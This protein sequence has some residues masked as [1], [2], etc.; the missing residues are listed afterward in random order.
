MT[1]CYAAFIG[2]RV[3][4]GGEKTL[5]HFVE[6]PIAI[7]VINQR[8]MTREAKFCAILPDKI[9]TVLP[10]YKFMQLFTK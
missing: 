7:C 4:T 9:L 1:T 3:F 10:G 6:A 8:L 2:V 5:N